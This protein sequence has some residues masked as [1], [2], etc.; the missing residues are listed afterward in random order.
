MY[1][2]HPAPFLASVHRVCRYACGRAPC[3][4]RDVAAT[5]TALL[6][7]LAACTFSSSQVSPLSAAH[8]APSMTSLLQQLRR[9]SALLP[10]R[11][12]IE[13]VKEII[14][15]NSLVL[16]K[17]SYLS[18]DMGPLLGRGILSSSGLIWAHQRNIIAPELYL[19]KVKIIISIKLIIDSANCNTD[20]EKAAAHLKGRAEKV[21]ISAQG[22]WLWQKQIRGNNLL[23]MLFFV[24]LFLIS[25]LCVRLRIH[26]RELRGGA[27]SSYSSSSGDIASAS[28]QGR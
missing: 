25:H 23:T 26:L 4:L 14:L 18:K 15:N 19:D 24:T 10:A 2:A 28:S 27:M 17:P 20:K 7:R 6:L 12:Y 21:F 22:I 9:S 13:M 16:G 5:A 1:A 11:C 8:P 3:S